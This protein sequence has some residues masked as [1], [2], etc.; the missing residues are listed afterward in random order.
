MGEDRFRGTGQWYGLNIWICWTALE[1]PA[2]MALKST[3]GLCIPTPATVDATFFDKGWPGSEVS[4]DLIQLVCPFKLLLADLNYLIGSFPPEGSCRSPFSSLCSTS[5][6]TMSA[7]GLVSIDVR[8]ELSI[9]ALSQVSIDVVETPG[10]TPASG[11]P[12]EGTPV[13]RIPARRNP[14]SPLWS[15]P[16]PVLGSPPSSGKWKT[17]DKE[18]LPYFRIWMSLTYSNGLRPA[19]GRLY[20]GNPNP[21]ARDRHFK[22]WRLGLDA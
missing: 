2:L 20:K 11:S 12:L 9:V 14:G 10:G 4:G 3:S 15:F 7:R 19:L 16:G 5:V 8:V 17:S 13:P 6:A 22:T 21:K 18:N 1:K